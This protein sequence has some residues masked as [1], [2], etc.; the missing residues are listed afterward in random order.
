MPKTGDLQSRLPGQPSQSASSPTDGEA[1]TPA[2][3]EER[4]ELTLTALRW[5]RPPFGVRL[6]ESFL[7]WALESRTER[8]A[9]RR[10][11]VRF[12]PVAS[13]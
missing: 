9:K 12:V 8:L 13:L 2:Q 6:S 4:P 5:G 3:V 7:R 11:R 10:T 1:P